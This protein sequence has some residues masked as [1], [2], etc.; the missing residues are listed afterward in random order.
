ME[1]VAPGAKS[2]PVTD[3]PDLAAF[4]VS[5]P[6]EVVRGENN[7]FLPARPVRNQRERVP[8]LKAPRPLF[9]VSAGTDGPLTFNEHTLAAIEVSFSDEASKDL[10]D[11]DSS[12]LSVPLPGGEM[13]DVNVETVISRGPDTTTFVGSV[14]GFKESRVHFV[15]HGGVV[16]GTLEFP[17]ENV[18]YELSSAGNGQTAVRQLDPRSYPAGCTSPTILDMDPAKAKVLAER[19]E[20]ARAAAASS[21]E[22]GSLATEPTDPNAPVAIPA[23]SAN[24]DPLFAEVEMDIVVGYSATAREAQGGVSEMEALIISTVE[25]LNS[26]FVASNAGD[27]AVIL[28]GM[29]EDPVYSDPGREPNNMGTTDELGDLLIE[30]DGSLDDVT[31][32]KNE[33]CAD[34]SAFIVNDFQGGAAGVAFLNSDVFIAARTYMTPSRLVFAHEY[35]HNLGCEHAWGDTDINT[36]TN[37]Y[38]WRF[39]NSYGTVM[40]YVG[41][42]NYDTTIGYFSNPDVDFDAQPTGAEDGFDATG[43]PAIDQSLVTQ[44]GLSGYDG[45]NPNLGAD[46]AG[47]CEAGAV[48]MA[49]RCDD[50]GGGGGPGGGNQNNQGGGGGGVITVLNDT[51]NVTIENGSVVTSLNDGTQFGDE[52][53]RGGTVNNVFRIRN[54]SSDYVLAV[55]SIDCASQHFKIVGPVPNSVATGEFDEFRVVYDPTFPGPKSAT[56]YVHT[57]DVFNSTYTFRVEGGAS[58]EPPEIELSG[59]ASGTSPIFDG[60]T[61]TSTLNGTDFG[62]A[63]ID[64]GLT[65]HTF[66]ISNVGN[67]L[68]Y[69]HSTTFSEGA[70]QISGVPVG[71]DAGGADT[72][73]IAFNPNVLGPVTGTIT[74]YNSDTDEA[75]YTFTVTGTG[76]GADQ[77]GGTIATATPVTSNANNAGSVGGEIQTSGDVDVF[78]IELTE[79]GTVNFWTTGPT[80]TVGVLTS[81]P[82]AT[83]T[84]TDDDSGANTN[85]KITQYLPAGVFYVSV[86]GGPG[87]TGAYDF[88]W[89]INAGSSPAKDF[90]GDGFPD[91][92]WRRSTDG[93]TAIHFYEEENF[94]RGRWTTQ[95]VSISAKVGGIGDFDGDGKADILFDGSGGTSIHF[96]DGE[97]Y[98]APGKW[99]SAQVAA[100]WEPVA[101]GD[102]DGDGKA[103]ILYQNSTNLMMAIHYMDAEVVT[104]Q[105]STYA[106]SWDVEGVADFNGDGMADL[107]LRNPTTK[108]AAYHY[109]SNGDFAGAGSPSQQVASASWELEGADD[110]DA[111]GSPDLLWRS[112]VDG[113]SVIHY[114]DGNTYIKGRWISSQVT[115]MSWFPILK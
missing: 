15:F 81:A 30:D 52:V 44:A 49:A 3:T 85:F 96:M 105:K 17:V 37:Y 114:Y 111:N 56:I 7:K 24:Q 83:I 63:D 87:A 104:S 25:R 100:P 106:V 94:L 60:S 59:G 77:H 73:T 21:G 13:A 67:G 1:Q 102:F 110:F 34:S 99:T 10:L 108:V 91:I 43:N 6:K 113:R 51:G 71:V 4:E 112:N 103:D 29:I 22:R 68:L 92:L 78:Q 82:P 50:G 26:I 39:G 45:T 76:T 90:D 5:E 12:V 107:L 18:H 84:A 28:S 20:L 69:V 19:G 42:N 62:I 97:T 35:G 53:V 41:P 27:I 88:R 14:E 64:T 109:L 54:S 66:T 36:N 40:A 80:D 38:G 95:E 46:N 61:T 65:P 23:G 70:F 48:V 93:A 89:T 2:A 115:N 31:N 11:S 86:Q 55:N 32:L 57:N 101:V 33:V 9:Q 72:F 8:G 16:H 75:A 98:L 47:I 74:V 58:V 79:P